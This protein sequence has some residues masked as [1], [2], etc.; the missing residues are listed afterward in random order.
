M[1]TI[2]A[3]DGSPSGEKGN[4]AL[5]LD[6]FLA[7]TADAGA[8]VQRMSAYK[9]RVERCN[10]R[11]RCWYATPGSCIHKDDMSELLDRMADADC[12]VLS[13]PVHVGGMT[14]GM[15]R[16]MERTMPLLSPYFEVRD[17]RTRHVVAPGREQKLTVLVSTCGLYEEAA[18]DPL[19]SQVA[20]FSQS[21]NRRFAGALLRPHGLAL[22]FM[23]ANGYDVDDVLN[24]AHAAGMELVRTGTISEGTLRKVRKPLMTQDEFVQMMNSAFDRRLGCSGGQSGAC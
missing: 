1:T 23:Q 22:K 24:A 17:G 4:T 20:D 11:M 19:V 8:E 15:V 12:W 9:M 18:L 16:V 7:G 10:S 5:L 3:I 2:L 13:T 14:E 6:R 21:H